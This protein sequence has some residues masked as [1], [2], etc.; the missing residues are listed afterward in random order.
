MEQRTIKILD[1]TL[2]DGLRNSGI[3][4]RL[5]QKVLFAQQLERLA[6]DVIEIGYGGPDEV[7]PMRELAAAV[8]PIRSCS[9]YRA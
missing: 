7:E 2:R 4:M 9:D 5:E 6:V 8:G 3:T 1:T